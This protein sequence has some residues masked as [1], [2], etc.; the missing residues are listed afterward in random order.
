MPDDNTTDSTLPPN[1]TAT[2]APGT[3]APEAQAAPPPAEKLLTQAEVNAIVAREKRAE[4]QKVEREL[5][6][7][8]PTPTQA[9]A[10]HPASPPADAPVTRAELEQMKRETKFATALVESGLKLNEKQRTALLPYFDM[11]NPGAIVDEAHEMFP[12]LAAPATPPVVQPQSVMA[13]RIPAPVQAGAPVPPYVSPG[14]PSGNPDVSVG[15]APSQWTADVIARKLADGTL[16]ADAR[17]WG[18]SLPGGRA[19]G[20]FNNRSRIPRK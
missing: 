12:H 3:P 19:K 4:R 11:S 8:T 18:N 1:G 7:A 6:A 2:E 13:P 16:T 17:E 10:A 9:T 14:A 20:L 5:K 15:S